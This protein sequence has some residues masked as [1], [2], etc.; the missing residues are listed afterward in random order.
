MQEVGGRAAGRATKETFGF[1]FLEVFIIIFHFW[2]AYL[3]YAT[4][5][6][7]SSRRIDNMSAN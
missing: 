1:F 5:V 4:V 2:Y 6:C 7:A 3:A